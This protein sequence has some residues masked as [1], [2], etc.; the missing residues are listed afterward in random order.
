LTPVGISSV[1][2]GKILSVADLSLVVQQLGWFIFTV[3]LGVLLYQLVIM[4]LIYFIIV[5][6]NPYKYYWGLVQATLTAFATAST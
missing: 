1:I 4:Q 6:R 3:A 5:R 2:C